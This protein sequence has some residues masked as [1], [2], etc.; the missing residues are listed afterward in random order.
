MYN[1]IESVRELSANFHGRTN[2]E[3]AFDEQCF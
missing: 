3:S 2:Y 1:W